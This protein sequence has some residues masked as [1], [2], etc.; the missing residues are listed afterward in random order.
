MANKAKEIIVPDQGV[1]RIVFLYVGQGDSAILTIP[2]GSDF[3][4][5]LLDNNIDISAGGINTVELLKDLLDDKKIIFMNTHPHKDHTEGIEEIHNEVGVEEVWHSGHVPG[6]KHD[7]AYQ[8]MRRVIKAIGSDNE[9]KF[10]GTNDLNKVRASDGETQVIKKIGDIDF[11]VLSPAEYLCEEIAGDD[12]EKR[13]RRIHEHC[14]VIKLTYGNPA[15]NILM[16][17]DAD[18]VAWED[19]ILNYH[20]DSVQAEVLSAVHHGSR[21]FFKFPNN[22]DDIY[23]THIETISPNYLI[24]SAPTQEESSH[25]HP[26]D[27]AMELYRKHLEEDNIFHLGNKRE[28]MIVDI[29]PNGSYVIDSDNG[30]LATEYGF[31]DHSGS[32]SEGSKKAAA[33]I[34]GV[35]TSTLDKKPMG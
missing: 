26:H 10:F 13:Y 31:D 6:K 12:A 22:D 33:A 14:A 4:Y 2:D 28:S 18:R 7:D 19:H 5:V 24:V 23:E 20:K 8:E 9:Y 32:D 3:R 27:D 1:F 25:D 11:H 30:E 16:T 17:G 35:R 21:T 29:Y 34:I 15:R